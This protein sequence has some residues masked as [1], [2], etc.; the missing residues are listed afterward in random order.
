MNLVGSGNGIR[1]N[2]L[3]QKIAEIIFGM[4]LKIPKCE[5][6]A[7]FGAALQSLVTSG[8]VSSLESVQEK[9]R[10]I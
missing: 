5:E 8:M 6:E 3:M 9:I 7:A 4:N 2:V 10:Y 1:K